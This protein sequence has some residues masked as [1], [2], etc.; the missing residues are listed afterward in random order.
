MSILFVYLYER[1]YTHTHTQRHVQKDERGIS[2]NTMYKKNFT[3]NSILKFR[4]CYDTHKYKGVPLIKIKYRNLC[5]VMC[6]TGNN[7]D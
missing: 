2:H 1:T 5:V 6:R 4:A 7:I 3:T